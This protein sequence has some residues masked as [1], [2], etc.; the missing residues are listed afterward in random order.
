MHQFKYP[1]PNQLH[2][3]PSTITNAVCVTQ[4]SHQLRLVAETDATLIQTKLANRS[5]G[6]QPFC[7][8][9]HPR[10]SNSFR[11]TFYNRNNFR[12][13]LQI[14]LLYGG[15]R[16]DKKS[17]KFC[18]FSRPASQCLQCVRFVHCCG[19]S[20]AKLRLHETGDA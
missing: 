18:L 14:N 5:T 8:P 4:L 13:V 15:I 7:Q 3:I 17:H 6:Q 11:K 16:G 2:W 12:L 1:R 9:I 10:C 19:V 20:A